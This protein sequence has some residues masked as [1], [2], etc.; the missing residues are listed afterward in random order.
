MMS[1]EESQVVKSVYT[2]L[3]ENENGSWTELDENLEFFSYLTN[4]EL[5]NESEIRY[6][7]HSK[8]VFRCKLSEDYFASKILESVG[9][10]ISLYRKTRALHEKNAYILLY[11]L[12]MTEM[13]LVYNDS[14]AV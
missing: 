13:G 3:L 2:R 10:I 12:V 6:I 5:I 11:Y 14:N 7:E 4:I 8:G 1:P 9:I